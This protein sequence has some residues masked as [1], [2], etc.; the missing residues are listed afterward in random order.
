MTRVYL[1]KRLDYRGGASLNSHVGYPAQ[2]DN[3]RQLWLVSVG[4]HGPY[5]PVL[6]KFVEKTEERR[7]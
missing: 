3:D 7:A 4:E 1:T 6:P 5:F 2:F